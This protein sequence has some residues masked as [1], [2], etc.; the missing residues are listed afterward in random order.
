MALPLIVEAGD[1]FGTGGA[2]RNWDIL[3][4]R[5][6]FFECGQK[7]VRTVRYAVSKYPMSM[8]SGTWTF[9]RQ[10]LAFSIHWV[11]GTVPWYRP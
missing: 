7:N 3:V 11:S 5:I 1:D 4:E 8:A 2:D 10:K 6:P 9:T